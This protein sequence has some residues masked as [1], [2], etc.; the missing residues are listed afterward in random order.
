VTSSTFGGLA[1]GIGSWPGT[2]VREAVSIVLG[3]LG[4]LPHVVELPGRGLGADMIG[5][6]GAI[7]VDVEL[8]VRTSGYRVVPRPMLA[9]PSRCRLQDRSPWRRRSNCGTDTVR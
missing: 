1:T 9:G 2:D 3:E 8:D 7:M 6:T 5:R 4:E